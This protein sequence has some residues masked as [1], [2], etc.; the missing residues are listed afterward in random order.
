L[1][2]GTTPVQPGT[3]L[4]GVRSALSPLTL[5]P[6]PGP[7]QVQVGL[8]G[9]APAQL[10]LQVRP[11]MGMVP[12]RFSLAPL[13]APLSVRTQDDVHVIVDDV[14]VGT[15]PLADLSLSPRPH[16]GRT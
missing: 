5:R 6:L 2:C 1:Q 4:D 8:A 15:T 7:H 12:L 10:Q 16:K 9:F 3:P 13:T 11:D 14:A